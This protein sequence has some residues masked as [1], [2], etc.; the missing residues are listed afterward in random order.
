VQ[1]TVVLWQHACCTERGKLCQIPASVADYLLSKQSAI[2]NLQHRVQSQG[3][4]SLVTYNK[5]QLLG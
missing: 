3:Q 5:Y 2:H 4:L 1:V